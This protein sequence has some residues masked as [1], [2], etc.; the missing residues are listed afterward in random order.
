MAGFNDSFSDWDSIVADATDEGAES[1]YESTPT[2]DF[3]AEEEQQL[4]AAEEPAPSYF[5]EQMSEAEQR[6]H[7]A[8]L[9]RHFLTGRVFNGA[10][11]QL[12]LE[13][14]QEFK[15]FAQHRLSVLLGI[16][17]S[18]TFG[19]QFTDVEARVLK[20]I[21]DSALKNAKVAK[22]TEKAP[23]PAPKPQTKKPLPPP[24]RPTLR[25][26][27]LPEVV[28]PQK[29][30]PAPRPQQVQQKPPVAPQRPQQPQQPPQKVKPPTPAPT[31][32]AIPQDGEIFQIAGKNYKAVW[33]QMSADEFGPSIAQKLERLPP[34]KSTVLPNGLQVIKTEGDEYYKIIKRDLTQQVRSATSIPFPSV[35]QMAAISAM[36]AGEAISN[37]PSSAQGLAGKLTE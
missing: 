33:S 25:Q 4:V 12:T 17:K 10:D 22:A 35:G 16:G 20:L 11:D 3:Y 31:A 1:E 18:S 19:S 5:D 9:Y 29:R 27:P 32:P 28:Q 8:T 15:E 23:P 34:G 7:K 30:Q 21:A 6:L 13:V 14:E 36:K 37:L 24:S 26:R 2:E